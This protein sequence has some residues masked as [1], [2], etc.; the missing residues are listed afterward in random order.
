MTALF[1]EGFDGMTAEKKFGVT[2]ARL[3][4][5]ERVGCLRDSSHEE[6]RVSAD[7]Y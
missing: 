4:P 3:A 6:R 1:T 7:G 2:A 5:W